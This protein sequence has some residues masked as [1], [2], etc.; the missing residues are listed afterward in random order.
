M[1]VNVIKINQQ[2]KTLDKTDKFVENE[3]QNKKQEWRADSISLNIK[4]SLL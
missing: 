4:Q 3:K 2:Q 1:V